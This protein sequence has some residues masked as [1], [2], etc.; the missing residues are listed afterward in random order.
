MFES[1][2]SCPDGTG[3]GQAV[4]EKVCPDATS[5]AAECGVDDHRNRG[6]YNRFDRRK[7][8]HH[9]A[10]FDGGHGHGSHD[11]AVK[12]HAEIERTEGS[13]SRSS[14][15]AVAEFVEFQVGHD[16]RSAP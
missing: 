12:K 4:L 3:H 11:D 14:F 5:E 9:L 16:F 2:H 10:N 15:A 1:F 6:V 13:Q 8:K 7:S